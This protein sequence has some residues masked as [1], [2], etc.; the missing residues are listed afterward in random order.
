MK[1]LHQLPGRLRVRLPQLRSDEYCHGLTEKLKG[2]ERIS[3]ISLARGCYSLTIFYSPKT[4]TVPEILDLLRREEPGEGPAEP[5]DIVEP[6]E[7]RVSA[8]TGEETSP[9]KGRRS[10]AGRQGVKPGAEA[11]KPVKRTVKRTTSSTASGKAATAGKRRSS[12]KEA[13]MEQI[14]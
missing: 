14:E 3:D 12:S 8:G 11:K 5:K 4:I 10:Q 6:T 13:S 7:E 1:I 2:D 9:G